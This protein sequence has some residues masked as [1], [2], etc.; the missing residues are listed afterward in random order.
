MAE[1]VAR[2]PIRQISPTRLLAGWEVSTRRS[3][4]SLRLADLTALTK[5]MIRT[6]PEAV[7]PGQTP[8]GRAVLRPNGWLEIGS[9]PGEWMVLGPIGSGDEI[10]SW[11]TEHVHAT[12]QPV[13][14]IDVT[15]GRA[16]IRLQ[17]TEAASLLAKVCSIDLADHMAPDGCAFRAPVANV[18]SDL[19]RNDQNGART[20]LIHCERSSGQYLV[21]TLL[22]AGAEFGV[23]LEGF[24]ERPF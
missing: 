6:S 19:V 11:M 23:E 17:G 18:V 4:A 1:P 9:G 5:V 3:E 20:Y 15:H 8:F 7:R 22:D 21:D 2:S 13:T 10:V 12:E 14:V 16:L 24:P